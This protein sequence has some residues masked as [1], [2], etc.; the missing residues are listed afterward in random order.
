MCAFRQL[1][2]FA[3]M[4]YIFRPETRENDVT[5]TYSTGI[6]S[7]RAR[8]SDAIVTVGRLRHVL[9]LQHL[10]WNRENCQSVVHEVG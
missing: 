1:R 6:E 3:R 7:R 9:A 8:D 2:F 4:S 10:A 5:V